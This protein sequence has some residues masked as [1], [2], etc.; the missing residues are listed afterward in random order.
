[1]SNE[2]YKMGFLDLFRLWTSHDL[3]VPGFGFSDRRPEFYKELRREDER[4]VWRFIEEGYLSK[5]K[6]LVRIEHEWFAEGLWGIPFP[7]SISL[8]EYL[9]P[10]DF[11]MPEVLTE[12]IRRWQA[13]Q[14]RLEPG[15][16]NRELSAE[17]PEIAKKVKL[18]LG[19]DYY[20]EY[21]T[22]REISIR[23]GEAVELDVPSFITDL[24]R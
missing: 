10:Q 3:G 9:S 20:V 21:R 15:E 5:Y 11:V 2:S 13:A 12:R 6:D 18:F 14:D 7:G 19:D 17:R 24:A 8:G 4:L 22:F 1:M 23:D 16:E